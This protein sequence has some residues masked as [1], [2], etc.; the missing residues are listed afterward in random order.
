MTVDRESL[1]RPALLFATAVIAGALVAGIAL[2]VRYIAWRREVHRVEVL[3]W[4]D[5]CAV[6]RLQTRL[7]AESGLAAALVEIRRALREEREVPALVSIPEE[8]R[9]GFGYVA[10][11]TYD[12]S[13]E[14]LPSGLYS[15][16]ATGRN[17]LRHPQDQ[18]SKPT[19]LVATAQV[20]S[21]EAVL[22]DVKRV[23]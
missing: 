22:L 20:T 4:E 17:G 13:V 14:R 12:V 9:G 8:G 2:A 11:E 1:A 6:A 3:Y 23:R 10:A 16:R 19:T 21:S 18:S 7:T 5:D 15:L